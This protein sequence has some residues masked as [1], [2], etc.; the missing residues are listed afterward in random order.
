M[1]RQRPASLDYGGFKGGDNDD[2]KEFR[3][4]KELEINADLYF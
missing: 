3:P 2:T 1:L 4:N